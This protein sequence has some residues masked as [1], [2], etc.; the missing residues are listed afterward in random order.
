[1]NAAGL[2]SKLLTFKKVLFELQPSVFFIEETK[3]KTSGK[4]KI[5]NYDIFE[6]TR[7]DREGGGLAI[8]CLKSLNPVWVREGDDKVEAI[9]V[10]I[11]IQDLKIRCCAAYGCQ[12]TDLNDRKK[13]FWDYLYDEVDFAKHSGAGL[14]LHFDGNLWAGNGII[15][16][17]PR[18]QNKNGKLFQEFLKNNPHLTVVNSLPLCEG[19]ITRRR[20]KD[21]ILE[22]SVLDFFV[23]CNLVLP[24]IT[25]MVIDDSKKH[26][27]T[28]YKPA[29]KGG[30]A[31]DS[32]HF[33]EFMD[34]NL[35]IIN[36]KPT[37]QEV[38]DF[39][40]RKSQLK[41]KTLTTDTQDFT[42]CFENDETSVLIQIEKWRR[43]LKSYCRKA[44]RKIRIRKKRFKPIN[45][46]ISKLI[47]EKN[48]LLTKKD[49]SNVE[50]EIEAIDRNISE[51]EALN[52]RNKIVKNF[53]SFSD[54]PETIN[55]QEMWKRNKKLWPKVGNNLPTAKKNHKGKLVSNPGAI[56]K[57]LAREYKDRLRR[58]PVRPD[59]TEIR[60]RRKEITKMKLKLA[61]MRKSRDWT[62]D[63][64]EEA[65]R[66]L[67]NNKSRDFEGYLN[68]LFKLDTIGDNLKK[69]LLV[70]F[71]KLKQMKLIP[72]FMNIC[73]VTTVPKKG[74]KTELRNER[75]IFRVPI[76]R[77]ILMRLLY[78]M[79]Y[80]EIDENMSDCQMGARKGKSCKNNI[81]IVNGIIHD[82]RK[83]RKMKP[84]TLQI[85]D[86]AQMFD[87]IDLN[88]AISDIYDAGLNDD[89]LVLLHEANKDIQ[90]SVKTNNGLTERQSLKDIVLQGD[91]WGSLLASV[92]VDS[93]GKECV[94]NG[95]GYMYK[96]TL[97]V[98]ILGMVDDMLGITEAGFKAQ[99]MNTF[100]NV[101]TAE[102][103]LQ[104]GPK[105]C[106][107][108]LVGKSPQLLNS[109]LHVDSWT[110]QYEDN[111]HTG[112]M[113]LVE[114]YD[115]QV[116]MENT[117]S[118]K[119]LGFVL[120]STGDNMV[121]IRQMK[122]K[123]VGIIRQI[124][125]RLD[126]LHLQKYYFEC[127]VIFMNCMLR[128]SILYAAETYYDLKEKELREIERIEEGF[129]RRLLKTSRGCPISQ[130][131]LSVGQIPA[132]FEIMKMRIMFLK[133]ILDEN[134]ESLIRKFLMIQLEQPTKGDW[135]STC[136]E[137]LKQLELPEEFNEI[138][139]IT[140]NK[141]GNMLNEKI[142]NV[143][144]QYLIKKQGQ[145]GS[146]V[147]HLSI[148]MADYLA[149]NN[150]GLTIDEKRNMFSVIN[151]MEKISY[152][153]PHKNEIDRC[154]C[155]MTE[156]ME[157]IYLCE[158]LNPEKPKISYRQL[159]IGNLGQKISVFRRFK[160]NFEERE[161]LRIEKMKNS[162]EEKYP[163]VIPDRDPLYLSLYS[164]GLN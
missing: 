55:L 146:E 47:N 76:V 84:V 125:N 15:P 53:K 101:K 82:V 162:E 159:F 132:R 44:F 156:N 19:L 119:Y 94:E 81:F 21:N 72:M 127:A 49:I 90:M 37:R 61:G 105:K 68:E 3:F 29:R 4:F 100:M 148:Q 88:Q 134:E 48:E 138:T 109:D 64:L 17:D 87:S 98:S 130:L 161:K 160:N 31:V 115:G 43:I 154:L 75:G 36:E 71:N 69:S 142:R 63:D 122:N 136:K 27:L 52:N 35:K 50:E 9:S 13:S 83:S 74:S 133:D 126:S 46:Q 118:Q 5:E 155:G 85:Y 16:G 6:L 67:K 25:R 26:I 145:K 80:W 92:Q 99:Q 38:Y 113:D 62:M 151:R 20:Y 110:V 158:M 7:N 93:I 78:N 152:N 112:D 40:N 79:K 144:L 57:L 34:L 73:N 97:L 54:H 153:F 1:M 121:N 137:N 120:S 107:S 131:Y 143:A 33:T 32:D 149:P 22:E 58:R 102:K 28:N 56:R 114:T 86:Y 18:P 123:S 108:M 164:N 14:V 60:I 77:Y 39:K 11:F 103:T 106:K 8:G 10:D 163:H 104:F 116:V 150:T 59:I 135:V 129:L 24:H 91:T 128:S 2:K 117:S 141:L 66:N 45:P 41:F 147:E 96:D 42:N 70:M 140:R 30:K 124:F 51:I 157:H 89:T 12:E 65:L 23:V 111:I 95:Y 139:R